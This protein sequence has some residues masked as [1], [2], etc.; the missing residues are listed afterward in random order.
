MLDKPFHTPGF[1]SSDCV[2]RRLLFINKGRV[3]NPLLPTQFSASAGPTLLPPPSLRNS[4]APVSLTPPHSFQLWALLLTHTSADPAVGL[5]PLSVS[6]LGPCANSTNHQN[7]CPLRSTST[8][9]SNS[10]TEEDLRL[11][12]RMKHPFYWILKTT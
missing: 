8:C 5:S 11:T 2:S 6:L 3:P 12:T 9:T 10:F 4:R 7:S 1:P